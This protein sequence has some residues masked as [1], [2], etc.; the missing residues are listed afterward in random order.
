MGRN[1]YMFTLH[2]ATNNM[3]QTEL[4]RLNR[5]K[6][7]SNNYNLKHNKPLIEEVIIKQNTN[8]KVEDET[9]TVLIADN[10]EQ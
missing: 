9:E 4:K 5:L 1:K 7:M 2:A 6:R 8:K 10:I 3:H